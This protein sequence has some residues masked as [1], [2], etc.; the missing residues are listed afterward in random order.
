M[1]TAVVVGRQ[2]VSAAMCRRSVRDARDLHQDLVD[3]DAEALIAVCMALLLVI[4]KSGLLASFLAFFRSN[5]FLDL[6]RKI[7]YS[8]LF[9]VLARGCYRGIRG[10]EV[11]FGSKE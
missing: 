11:I 7:E 3:V 2:E 10:D 6:Y 8:P 5:R 4:G 1:S 9:P